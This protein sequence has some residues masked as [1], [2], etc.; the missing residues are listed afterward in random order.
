MEA[1]E[2]WEHLLSEKNELILRAWRSLNDEERAAVR[3]HLQAMSREDG[4][5]MGQ[6]RAALAALQ[7]IEE[8]REK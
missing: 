6:R 1:E 4:W 7:C 2:L 3:R 8:P 5:H